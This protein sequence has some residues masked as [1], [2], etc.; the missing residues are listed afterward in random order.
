MEPITGL[1]CLVVSLHPR[2]W[3]SLFAD[4]VIAMNSAFAAGGLVGSLCTSSLAD[5]L[6][7]KLTI[8]LIAITSIFATI[9][10]T[11]SVHVI[12]LV[13]GRALQGVG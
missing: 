12:M 1:T 9:L 11:G 6:G 7:R 4:D 8:Q 3:S 5:R 10:S 13:V 2:D